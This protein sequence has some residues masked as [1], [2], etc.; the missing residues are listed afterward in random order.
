[1]IVQCPNCQTS[2]NLDEGRIGPSGSKVRCS[3]CQH[4]FTVM[5]PAE[6]AAP[7]PPPAFERP[8]ADRGPDPDLIRL[9]DLPGLGAEPVE[10]KK[11]KKAKKVKKEKKE[12]KAVAG[13]RGGIVGLV[14]WLVLWAILACGWAYGALIY[15]DRGTLFGG[16]LAKVRKSPGIQKTVGVIRNMPYLRAAFSPR[17]VG[18]K[19]PVPTKA[20]V[21]AA[22]APLSFVGRR[23]EFVSAGK[24]GRRL[25]ISG[26]IKNVGR[27]PFSFIRLKGI[28]YSRTKDGK[29]V[30][31]KQESVYAGV[32]IAKKE[33]AQ[34][35]MA[36]IRKRLSNP[37]GDNR[38][39][40]LLG[41]GQVI[42]FM[43]VFDDLPPRLSE[44]RVKF[45]RA[46]PGKSPKLSPAK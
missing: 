14:L 26:R 40:Y 46:V 29:N 25:V 9:E 4:V 17:A 28:L 43:V 18:V 37:Y 16:V 39:N 45:E 32:M 13:A 6:A 12:K 44:Y 30:E 38:R 20:P 33:L 27:Q 23:Y 41:P 7:P 42:D 1:M 24:S 34:L 5:A 22:K 36:D 21:I 15:V 11:V 31:V 3:N 8:P 35:S 19:K 2:Y 10:G